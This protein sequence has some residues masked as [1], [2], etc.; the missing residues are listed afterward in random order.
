MLGS[1]TGMSSPAMFASI[2]IVS[3]WRMKSSLLAQL[4]NIQE[5]APAVGANLIT[6][7]AW[8]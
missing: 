4:K 8:V 1:L 7:L 2:P 5:Q 6:T 3:T